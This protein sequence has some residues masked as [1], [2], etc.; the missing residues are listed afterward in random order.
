MIN[1]IKLR[2]QKYAWTRIDKK[3]Q[4]R[5]FWT[6]GCCEKFQVKRNNGNPRVSSL[7][8]YGQGHREKSHLT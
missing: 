2:Q 7:K 5:S 8:I 4:I 3:W 1:N 6:Y